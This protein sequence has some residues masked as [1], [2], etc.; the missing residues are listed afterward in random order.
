MNVLKNITK[1][2]LY[3]GR[4]QT[5]N[6][7]SD[8][9]CN[10]NQSTTVRPRCQK[11]RCRLMTLDEIHELRV[12]VLENKQTEHSKR[13]AH[14]GI[15]QTCI[16]RCLDPHTINSWNV[17][18]TYIAVTAA[19][20]NYTRP[21]LWKSRTN[22]LEISWCVLWRQPS[23]SDIW[24]GCRSSDA[25]II[26]Y[27]YHLRLSAW[28]RIP[29]YDQHVYSLM[30][31]AFVISANSMSVLLFALKTL[32]SLTCPYKWI[33]GM[34]RSGGGVMAVPPPPGARYGCKLQDV[35]GNKYLSTN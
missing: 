18:E 15:G 10:F 16:C 33:F 32:F 6:F 30:L 14:I 22:V 25:F 24:L 27:Q 29:I 19:H 2:L 35:I 31:T 4:L 9:N 23:N 3:L 13:H 28:T 5:T 34:A 12:T 1:L 21:A 26:N 7:I 20:A 8:F 17:A 11:N